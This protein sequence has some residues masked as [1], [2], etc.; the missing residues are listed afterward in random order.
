VLQGVL[1]T[2]FHVC[3][4]VCVCGGGGRTALLSPSYVEETKTSK[5]KGP[6]LT[7]GLDYI[8]RVH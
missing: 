8:G 4:C 7:F 6:L 3:I 2:L 5:I 1:V